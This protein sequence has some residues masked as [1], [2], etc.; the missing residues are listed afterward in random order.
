MFNSV[1][2]S[3]KTDSYLEQ[4]IFKTL[5]NKTFFFVQSYKCIHVIQR[6]TEVSLK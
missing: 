1:Y 4:S 5:P 2:R 6:L 3:R